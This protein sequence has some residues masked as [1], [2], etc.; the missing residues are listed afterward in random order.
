MLEEDQ[1]K[2]LSKLNPTA[3]NIID[4]SKDKKILKQKEL[5]YLMHRLKSYYNYL[6]KSVLDN[7]S[8]I[9]QQKMQ[10]RKY[11]N[12]IKDGISQ[13]K[14]CNIFEDITLFT[15][16]SSD[17]LQLRVE[18]LKN[19]KNDLLM[20]LQQELDY[21]Q[22]LRTKL[23]SEREN[24][25][26]YNDLEIE[27]RDK[28]QSIA[29]SLS[30]LDINQNEFSK[31]TRNL[32]K[33]RGELSD[34]MDTMNRLIYTQ[35]LKSTQISKK[36]EVRKNGLIKEKEKLTKNNIKNEKNTIDK[37]NH[38]KELMRSVDKIKASKIEKETRVIKTILGLDLIKRY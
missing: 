30:S 7:N 29:K 33:I 2:L 25:L 8:I 36:L 31:K 22:S 20:K 3:Y 13:V 12:L 37:K 16:T 10:E 24:I 15:T 32:T 9:N 38:Y 19:A 1:D 35:S 28:I 27:V 14:E 18:N 4:V 21:D 11:D 5:T 6:Q 26:Y 17:N 34:K 23:K